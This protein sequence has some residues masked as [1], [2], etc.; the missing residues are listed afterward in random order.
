MK[1]QEYVDLI[2]E[3]KE[4]QGIEWDVTTATLAVYQYMRTP[5]VS[6]YY[7]HLELRRAEDGSPIIC[8][9]NS[10]INSKIKS[11]GRFDYDDSRIVNETA[12]KISYFMDTKGN[13]P[14]EKIS[15]STNSLRSQMETLRERFLKTDS[16]SEFSDGFDLN[17]LDTLERQ[18][19][20][21]SKLDFKV[22]NL[23]K[24]ASVYNKMKDEDDVNGE[25]NMT[26]LTM[27][28]SHI[29]DS[30]KFANHRHQTIVKPIL[31]MIEKKSDVTEQQ[32]FD[33]LCILAHYDNITTDSY[34]FDIRNHKEK[35][36]YFKRLSQMPEIKEN[37]V[38]GVVMNNPDNII[39]ALAD[40]FM[41][42][43]LKTLALIQTR[44]AIKAPTIE[45]MIESK[46]VI[47]EIYQEAIKRDPMLL[48]SFE[49]RFQHIHIKDN[50]FDLSGE[51]SLSF[52][53]LMDGVGLYG[54]DNKHHY[55]TIQ[56]E[57]I[58]FPMGSNLIINDQPYERF[59]GHDGIGPYYVGFAIETKLTNEVSSLVFNKIFISKN[60]D[61]DHVKKLFENMFENCMIRKIALVIEDMNFKTVIGE[62]NFDIFKG[63]Q[64]KYKGIVPTIVCNT[65]MYK[66]KALLNSDLN[67][68]EVIV[69]ED[70]F[71]TLKPS[72]NETRLLIS[73]YSDCIDSFVNEKANTKKITPKL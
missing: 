15:F 36:E 58:V 45:E 18:E 5:A 73:D 34:H 44:L 13:A 64:E 6:A 31:N 21:N 2:R 59:Y 29:D 66:Y 52:S 11:V 23:L 54:E 41:F 20:F 16:F 27:L 47:N 69:M 7:A 26:I 48:S 42:D 71:K 51:K 46:P 33:A 50:E 43:E 1:M 24:F 62:R 17:K 53:T 4:K 40:K 67:Y 8:E 61:D 25:K 22:K 72:K 9:V 68:N 65:D 39:N 3:K 38:F 28:L 70:K 49:E 12:D 14:I 32:E 63:L 19:L 35:I 56:P 55:L 10:N 57:I 30:Y 60:L 37:T